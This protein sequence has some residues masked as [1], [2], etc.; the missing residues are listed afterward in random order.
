VGSDSSSLQCCRGRT[1]LHLVEDVDPEKTARANFVAV[2]LHGPRSQKLVL[3]L[4]RGL[5]IASYSPQKSN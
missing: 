1:H 5:L 2:L 3:T 4:S